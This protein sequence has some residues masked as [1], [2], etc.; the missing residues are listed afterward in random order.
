LCFQGRRR[1]VAVWHVLT[2]TRRSNADAKHQ[3]FRRS[4][5]VGARGPS[6][7][8]AA[9]EGAVPPPSSRTFMSELT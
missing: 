9:N 5:L 1:R 4:I 6:Q 2:H 8:P 3:P 7:S